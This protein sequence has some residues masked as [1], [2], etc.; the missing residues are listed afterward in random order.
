[1]AAGIAGAQLSRR[2]PEV[3]QVRATALGNALAAAE[4]RAGANYGWDAVTAWPR[5]YPVLTDPIRAVVDARRDVLDSSAR[6]ALTG[7]LTA[8]A[9]GVLLMRSGWWSLLALIPLAVG[10]LAYLGA[11]RAA[12]AYGEA[13]AVAFDLCRFTLLTAL[14]LP[15]P[16]NR[17]VERRL[18]EGLC[19]EWRQGVQLPDEYFHG[20]ADQ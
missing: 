20:P 10:W 4:Q 18:S 1:V 2:Y 15:L 8:V 3:D 19:L 7:V 12:I 13:I 5:V 14:H 6:V 11:V 17:D 9:S 16:P